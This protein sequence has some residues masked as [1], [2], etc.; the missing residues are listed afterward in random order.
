MNIYNHLSSRGLTAISSEFMGKTFQ[1]AQL[2]PAKHFL[3]SAKLNFHGPLVCST[4]YMLSIRVAK[5]VTVHNDLL[6]Q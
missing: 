2:T 1:A 3:I 5:V 4:T 6:T